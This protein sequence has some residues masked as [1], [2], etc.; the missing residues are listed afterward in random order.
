MPGSHYLNYLGSK[1]A[2]TP[3]LSRVRRTLI[4]AELCFLY[5]EEGPTKWEEP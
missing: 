4:P 2:R 5:H 1:G 3:D